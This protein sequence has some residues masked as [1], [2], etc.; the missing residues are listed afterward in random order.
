[1]SYPEQ[2][3]WLISGDHLPSLLTL[4]YWKYNSSAQSLDIVSQQFGNKKNQ[5]GYR[6]LVQFWNHFLKF[7]KK[8]H[9]FEWISKRKTEN[10]N[11]IFQA[12]RV[13]STKWQTAKIWDVLAFGKSNVMIS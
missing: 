13:K 2:K 1:M 5:N 6:K 10:K 4:D 7:A 11:W 12:L 3:L 9:Y 8:N